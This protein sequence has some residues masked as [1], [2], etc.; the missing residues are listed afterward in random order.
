MKLFKKTVISTLIG[1]T[2]VA[3]SAQ[4]GPKPD[5]LERLINRFDA[6]GFDQSR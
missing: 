6:D 1:L 2:V 3:G 5:Q 4:A